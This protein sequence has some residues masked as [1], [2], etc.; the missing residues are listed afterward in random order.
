MLDLLLVS[1]GHQLEH[2]R[3]DVKEDFKLQFRRLTPS[4]VHA[5]RL[6]LV[7]ANEVLTHTRGYKLQEGSQVLQA[8]HQKITL[9]KLICYGED[10]TQTQVQLP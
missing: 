10:L 5:L 9:L 2:P 8:Q 7:V 4:T 3:T 1:R 6:N